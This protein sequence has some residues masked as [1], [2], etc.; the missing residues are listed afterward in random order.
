METAANHC[1]I[2]SYGARN[3]MCLNLIPTLAGIRDVPCGDSATLFSA[4]SFR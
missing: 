2:R 4:S 1:Y 3:C